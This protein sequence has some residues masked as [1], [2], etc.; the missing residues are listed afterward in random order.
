MVRTR[1]AGE[2][3]RGLCRDERIY[4]KPFIVSLIKAKVRAVAK[5]LQQEH[6]ETIMFGG[7][8]IGLGDQFDDDRRRVPR[9]SSYNEIQESLEHTNNSKDV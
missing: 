2:A 4:W 9:A 3:A 5:V 7:F 8:Y 6:A 1:Q